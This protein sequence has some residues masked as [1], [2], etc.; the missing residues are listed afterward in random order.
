MFYGQRSGERGKTLEGVVA[1]DPRVKG[2]RGGWL[3]RFAGWRG[4]IDGSRGRGST[5]RKGRGVRQQRHNRSKHVSKAVDALCAYAR[6]FP[7]VYAR[8]AFMLVFFFAAFSFLLSPPPPRT[9]SLSSLRPL[10]RTDGRNLVALFLCSTRTPV[11]PV[12]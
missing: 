10:P 3:S 5:E 4:T 7:C 6:L 9:S 8:R 11:C 2:G 1:R 12:V